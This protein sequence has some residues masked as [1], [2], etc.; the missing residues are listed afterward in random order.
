[1]FKNASVTTQINRYPEGRDAFNKWIKDS[2]T[3]NK[4]YSQMATELISAKGPNTFTQG[5]L[6][7]IVGGRVTGG[8]IQDTWDQQAANVAETFPGLGNMN[9]LLCHNG[10]GHLDTLN[11]WASQ[12]PRTT[13]WQ[14]SAFFSKAN[15]S[16]YRP[17]DRTMHGY[18]SWGPTQALA[19]G[20]YPLNT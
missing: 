5:E 6:N 2:L 17:P 12:T 11:L 3:A 18:W 7:W 14:M 19:A 16:Q 1:L 9:C 13:A 10:R 15:L 4:P 20:A 8:P